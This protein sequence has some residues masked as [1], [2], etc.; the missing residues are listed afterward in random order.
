MEK[1]NINNEP[2]G[3]DYLSDWYIHSVSEDDTPVWTEDHLDELFNDF[4]LIPRDTS[5]K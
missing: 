2:V 1:T 4:I 5:N 3:R